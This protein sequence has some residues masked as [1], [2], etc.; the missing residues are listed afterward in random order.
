MVSNSIFLDNYALFGGGLYLH[1]EYQVVFIIEYCYFKG[2]WAIQSKYI[3]FKIKKILD[4]GGMMLEGSN[5]DDFLIHKNVFFQNFAPTCS[6][7]IA[8]VQGPHIVVQISNLFLENYATDAAPSQINLI[9]PKAFFK[10]GNGAATNGI[11][12]IDPMAF[13]V[14]VNDTY[15]KNFAYKLG[16]SCSNKNLVKLL[17]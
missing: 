10:P 17:F 9:T 4:A 3:F 6:A 16:F 5:F 11:K 7:L 12:C 8:I 15:I 2:N 1:S 14:S 13:Y